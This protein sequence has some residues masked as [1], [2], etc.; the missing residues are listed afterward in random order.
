MKGRKK[1]Q[2]A[3]TEKFNKFHDYNDTFTYEFNS[4]DKY[5][6]KLTEKRVNAFI[7]MENIKSI[8]EKYLSKRVERI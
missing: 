1:V 6:K 2:N 4:V 7:L 3:P 5:G 8:K